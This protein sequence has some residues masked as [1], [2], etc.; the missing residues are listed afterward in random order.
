MGT[1]ESFA[2]KWEG[3]RHVSTHERSKLD[4]IA[5][6]VVTVFHVI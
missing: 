4:V 6:Q 5:S 2:W 3:Q 1:R